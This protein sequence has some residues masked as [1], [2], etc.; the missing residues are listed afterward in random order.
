M[1]HYPEKIDK[2]INIFVFKFADKKKKD[3][4]ESNRND[5]YCKKEAKS[6]RFGLCCCLY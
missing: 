3:H 2:N 5:T 1:Q 4:R 6:K